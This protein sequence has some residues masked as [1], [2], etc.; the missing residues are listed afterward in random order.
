MTKKS[1]EKTSID[2]EVENSNEETNKDTE[3][4]NPDSNRINKKGLL[5]QMSIMLV[6]FSAL[7]YHTLRFED[8]PAVYTSISIKTKLKNIINNVAGLDLVKFVYNK[9]EIQE[10][11]YYHLL[12]EKSSIYPEPISLSYILNEIKV[13]HFLSSDS[14]IKINKVDSIIKLHNQIYPFDKLEED[15]KV[16][17]DN[18]RVKSGV[19]YDIIKTDI[20]RIADDLTNKNKLVEDYL[21]KSELSFWISIGALILTFIFSII[22]ISQSLYYYRKSK[23][24]DSNIEEDSEELGSEAENKNI[25]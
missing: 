3:V 9:R 16:M 23:S 25:E 12:F 11:K 7:L 15:Q 6:I 10:R 19:N 22:Q 13:D 8:R 4:E 17:F 21:G 2:K 5:L 18:I 1:K 20:N 24:T 14:T